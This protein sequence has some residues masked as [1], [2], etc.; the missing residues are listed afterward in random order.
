M[1]IQVL[2]SKIH[3]VKV[4]QAELHYVGS[5]TIDEALMEASN[6]IENEKVQIV[7]INNG[8]R[9]ETYVIKG[10]KNSGVICLNGPAARKVAVGD[11]VIVISYATID[12][13]DDKT[14]KPTLIFP[15]ADNRLS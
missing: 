7:N 13:E 14:W 8:E 1:H 10:P 4:T 3:R 15:D 11:V 9:F 12:F 2:K 5:I 6:I